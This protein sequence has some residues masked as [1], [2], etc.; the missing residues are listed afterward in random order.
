MGGAKLDPFLRLLCFF[1][2]LP[3]LKPTEADLL[4]LATTPL[5]QAEF[6]ADVSWHCG[7]TGISVGEKDSLWR[8]FGVREDR[9]LYDI[10]AAAGQLDSLVG[11]GSKPRLEF[12]FEECNMGTDGVCLWRTGRRKDGSAAELLLV[13]LGEGGQPLLLSHDSRCV[14]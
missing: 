2:F 7:L 3:L 10:C 11:C 14:G 1:W 9:C 8:D 5:L 13:Q 12:F 4:A 6:H